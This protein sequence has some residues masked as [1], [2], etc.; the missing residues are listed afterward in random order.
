[1]DNPRGASQGRPMRGFGSRRRAAGSHYELWN[2]RT[3]NLYGTYA[4]RR[5]AMSAVRAIVVAHGPDYAERFILATEDDRGNTDRIAG[6]AELV[7][8]ANQ[9]DPER[10]AVPG[11]SRASVDVA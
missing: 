9:E 8:L 2:S 10:S 5:Q 1:M 6:G 3:K 4:S 7:R 11:P